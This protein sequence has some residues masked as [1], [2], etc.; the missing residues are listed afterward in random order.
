ML[1]Y[2]YGKEME[3]FMVRKSTFIITIC[4]ML[5]IFIAT[6]VIIANHYGNQNT[7]ISMPTVVEEETNVEALLPGI[8]A[9]ISE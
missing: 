7:D 6:I 2:T 8:D 4:I 1:S 5:V 3:V 9:E